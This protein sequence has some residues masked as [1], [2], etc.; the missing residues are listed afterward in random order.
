MASA[1][2]QGVPFELFQAFPY[3]AVLQT[4][5]QLPTAV[6]QLK[7]CRRNTLIDG[8]GGGEDYDLC[9]NKQEKVNCNRI[10]WFPRQS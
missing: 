7:G 2:G 10:D 1:L 4:W 8:D 5:I 9:G 6:R 3:S